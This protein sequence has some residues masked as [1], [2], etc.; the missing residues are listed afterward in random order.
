MTQPGGRSPAP[1]RL[2][3]VQDFVNTHDIENGRDRVAHPTRLRDWLVEGS[4][5]ERDTA[6]SRR[7][8]RHAL[9]V[10]DALRAL[11]QANNGAPAAP[12]AAE[13]LSR[14]LARSCP[15]LRL[16]A[17]PEDHS[18]IHVASGG[19][20]GALGELL[21]VVHEAMREGS[22]SRMKACVDD[23]CRWA[24]YDHSRN[25]SGRWCSMAVC[26]TRAK[27][28]ATAAR[29]GAGRSRRTP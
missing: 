26:G 1:G 18:E 13:L 5:L 3:L 19:V 27:V 14:A 24:F 12:A 6:V 23:R 2:R 22:W 17:G 21:V 7:E 28:E 8:H 29:T 15:E 16:A 10:R 11:M 9:E 20:A 4:L 25:A